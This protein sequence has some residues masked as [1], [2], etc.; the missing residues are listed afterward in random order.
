[1]DFVTI[2]YNNNI[3]IKLLEIQARS[4]NYLENEVCN[5]IILFFMRTIRVKINHLNF[6]FVFL[7]IHRIY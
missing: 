7:L 5:K 6:N 3:D 2:F 1:M 4:F